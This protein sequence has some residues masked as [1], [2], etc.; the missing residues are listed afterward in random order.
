[1]EVAAY[2]EN[3]ISN[4]IPHSYI[5]YNDLITIDNSHKDFWCNFGK[6]TCNLDRWCWYCFTIIQNSFGKTKANFMFYKIREL[7]VSLRSFLDDL[8]NEYYP[9]SINTINDK[10]IT[11]IFYNNEDIIEYSILLKYRRKKYINQN[12]K[13]YITSFI[14]R[15]NQYYNFIYNNID[16]LVEKYKIQYISEIKKDIIKT[17][18][19]I[20]KNCD[21][22]AIIMNDIQIVED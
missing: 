9:L 16:K 18:K 15:I 12:Q 20:K 1:M 17:I 3:Y 22:L 4:Y 13:V 11:H 6:E 5:N 14:E 19:N 7:F 21:R 8:V 2:N 10:P